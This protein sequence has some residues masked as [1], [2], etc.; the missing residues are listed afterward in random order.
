MGVLVDEVS[1]VQDIMADQIEPTPTFGSA[2]RADFIRGVGKLEDRVIFI[3][4]ID[5]V[6]TD[7]ELSVL[8]KT[9]D[10]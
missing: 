5:Q 9:E 1:D 10:Q 8:K 6:L 7:Q 2:A 3:L 4:D